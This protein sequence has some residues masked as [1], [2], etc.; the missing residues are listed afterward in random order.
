[1]RIFS[2]Q[3]CKYLE[4]RALSMHDIEKFPLRFLDIGFTHHYEI[5][6]RVELLEERLFYIEQCA[7]GFLE[8]GETKILPEKQFIRKSWKTFQQLSFYNFR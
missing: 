3:W 2:E 8:C 6:K 4:L 7:A 1:M 5:L